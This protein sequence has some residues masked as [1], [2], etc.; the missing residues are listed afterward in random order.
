MSN[1]V[2][3]KQKFSHELIL[4]EVPPLSAYEQEPVLNGYVL[5]DEFEALDIQEIIDSQEEK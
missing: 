1:K 4:S 3:S 5:A 2:Q